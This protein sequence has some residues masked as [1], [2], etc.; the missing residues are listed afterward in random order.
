MPIIYEIEGEEVEVDNPLTD[1]EIDE[2]GARIRASTPQP[3]SLGDELKRGAGLAGRAL[4]K[5][6]L[7]GF[8]VAPVFVD[9]IQSMMGVQTTS[10][11]AENV[12]D[13][14]GLPSPETGAERAAGVGIE[15]AASIGGQVRGALGLAKG[16]VAGTTPQ[17][18]LL[19]I[20]DDLGQQLATGIPAAMVA[21]Q[22]ASVADDNNADPAQTALAALA[23]GLFAGIAGG[24]VQRKVTSPKIPLFTP[25][26]AKNQARSSY[27]K[28]K[29]AGISIK[30]NYVSNMVDDIERGLVKSEGGYYPD[31]IKE[32]GQVKGVL[33]GFKRVAETGD[34]SFETLDKLRSDALAF[35]RESGDPSTRRLMGQVVDGIDLKISTIQPANLQSGTK[36]SLGR[37]L[38]DVRNAREAWRRSAK[39]NILEDALEAAVRRGA[40][41]TGKEGE[42]IRKNFE[43]LYAN[44]KT[45]KLFTTEEQ[46]AIKQ[47]AAGGKGLERLLNFTARFNPARDKF[48]TGALIGGSLAGAPE[49]AVPLAATGFL[50]DVALQQMQTRAAKN[51]LSQIASGNIKKPRTDVAW[52]ALVEAE[53]RAM[54]AGQEFEEFKNQPSMVNMIPN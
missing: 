11:A 28:V 49:I 42:I 43:N 30:P 10:Q 40:S 4:G 45:M 46:E 16:V 18:V 26:M 3:V 29:D 53:V 23:G 1:A 25:E 54:Q 27:A 14:L 31:A 24:K 17:R 9:P 19:T 33:Q 22:I 48:T 15:T 52:R 41:P 5:A 44:K 34:V 6:A 8:G 21:D 38:V 39:A 50:S 47:V 13:R 35:A 32:H 2:I 36:E 37:S 12:L 20:G 51:V 7:T